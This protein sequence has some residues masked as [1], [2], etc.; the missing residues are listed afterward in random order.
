MFDNDEYPW[1]GHVHIEEEVL[2]ILLAYLLNKN[3][4]HDFVF[5]C[6]VYAV[7]RDMMRTDINEHFFIPPLV[8]R[9][10]LDTK[11]CLMSE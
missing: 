4:P 11:L 8:R 1:V 2:E 10:L 5:F 7:V 9:R 6:Y 3:C